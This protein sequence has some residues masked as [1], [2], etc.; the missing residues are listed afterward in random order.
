[1]RSTQQFS[2]TLP[3]EMA[4]KILNRCLCKTNKFS[5]SIQIELALIIVLLVHL[6]NYTNAATLRV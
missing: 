6:F 4:G 3:N 1:M 5:I 2:I